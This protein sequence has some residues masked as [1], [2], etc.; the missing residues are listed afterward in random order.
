MKWWPD[1]PDPTLLELMAKIEE[2]EGRFNLQAAQLMINGDKLVEV[3]ARG[4][5]L[6]AKLD[7]LKRTVDGEQRTARPTTPTC[8]T[9]GRESATVAPD[10]ECPTCGHRRA[11]TAAERMKAYRARK[12][13]GA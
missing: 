7:K 10:G 1:D 4:R 8:E 12:R 5:Y 3:I 11:R 13:A 6:E 9:G 2:L